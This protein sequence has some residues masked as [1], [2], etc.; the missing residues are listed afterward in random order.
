MALFTGRRANI[1]RKQLF[2]SKVDK[3]GGEQ[4]WEWNA[5]INSS[6]YGIFWYKGKQ[7][8]AHRVAWIFTNGEISEGMEILHKCDNRK[9]CKPEHLYLGT[10][11]DNMRDRVERTPYNRVCNLPKLHTSDIINIRS[12]KGVQSSRD[13][14]AIYKVDHSTILNIWK[15]ERYLSREGDYV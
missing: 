13:I 1:D 7:C 4:C 9:C 2:W 3:L 11:S 6:G 15:T 12:L 5:G 10:Q 14:G 8:N